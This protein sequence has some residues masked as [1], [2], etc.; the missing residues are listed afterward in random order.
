MERIKSTKSNRT[1]SK[2][3]SRPATKSSRTASSKPKPKKDQQPTEPKYR[4][5]NFETIVPQVKLTIKLTNIKTEYSSF[6]LTVP[7]TTTIYRLKQLIHKKHENSCKNLKIY[8][9]H[10]DRS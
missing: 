2:Y 3:S 5:I 6:E 10:L 7:L 4:P 9:D 1:T 8:L